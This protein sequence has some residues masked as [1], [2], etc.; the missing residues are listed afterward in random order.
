MTIEL[1]KQTLNAEMTSSKV[2][3]LTDLLENIDKVEVMSH[4]GQTE[5]AVWDLEHR[6]DQVTKFCFNAIWRIST[7]ESKLESVTFK[8][9]KND[10]WHVHFK[11]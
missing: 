5:S 1:S 8:M 11:A 6:K 7:G 9:G 3:N 10:Y 2:K 4:A